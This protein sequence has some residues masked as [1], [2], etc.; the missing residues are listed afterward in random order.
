MEFFLAFVG[1]ASLLLIIYLLLKDIVTPAVAF[2]V[3][4]GCVGIALVLLDSYTNLGIAR[5]LKEDI[6]VKY[7]ANID[8][9]VFNF[10]A[11]ANFIKSGISNVTSTAVLFI[12]SILFFGILNEAGVFNKIINAL[13]KI[14]KNNVYSICIITV[15]VSAIVHL[16]GSGAAS[17]LIVIP[18]MLPIYEK[19]GMKRTTLMTIMAISLGIMNV[20]PW[21]GPTMR[22]ATIIQAEANDIWLRLIPIQ[23]AGLICALGIAIFMARLEVKQGAG[24]I[25]ITESHSIEKGEHH[26][27]SKLI[28]NIFL[29]IAVIA[30]L[31]ANI[32]PGYFPF[33]LGL[34]FALF[35]NYPDLE[36]TQKLIDKYSKSAMMMATT[37]FGAGILIG[38]FDNSGIMKVMAGA[39]LHILPEWAVIL[40]PLMV[41]ISAVPLALIFCTDS[42]F[43]GVMPIVVGITNSLGID[44]YSIAII[45]VVAR[46][47]ATFIS[48][49]VP[50]TLLGCGL[51]KVSIR[52]HIKKSFFWVWGVSFI[53]LA[54]G[55]ILGIVHFF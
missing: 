19:L 16:D 34:C 52:E 50:A 15:V 30:L 36:T 55:T 23:I 13:L 39:I 7:F 54:T 24:I 29:I 37:I 48:P 32:F 47:C 42:Y 27:D 10:K 1:F 31:V 28:I 44:P 40:I 46:N 12:F 5:L 11:L 3:V 8:N 35:I 38:V 51:A 4:S 20:L 26:R 43:F 18:A 53:C 33:M 17:F 45:M 14:S 9:P 21:G 2:I 49:V 41:G 25:K 22:A 6:G